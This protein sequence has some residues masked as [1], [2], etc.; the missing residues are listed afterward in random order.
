MAEVFNPGQATQ[1]WTDYLSV[2][3]AMVGMRTLQTAAPTLTTRYFH[4]DNLGSVSV[5]LDE[6]GP[7][8]ERLSYDAWGKRRFPNGTD[9]PQARSP[10][11]PQGL[12]R[13]GRTHRLRPRAPERPRL[14]SAAGADDQRGSDRHRSDESAGLEPLLLCQQ[15]PA[16]LHR[17]ERLLAAAGLRLRRQLFAHQRAGARSCRAR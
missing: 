16:R 11:R 6:N 9:E 13:P 14:R 3:N 5:I 10:A 15:R 12:Y 2:G 17:S 4:T 7:V 1:R 8:V